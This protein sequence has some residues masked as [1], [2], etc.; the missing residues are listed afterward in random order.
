MKHFTVTLLFIS[1]F[2]VPASGQNFTQQTGDAKCTAKFAQALAIRGVHLGLSADELL[3]M[4][5]DVVNKQVITQ[6][7]EAA[8]DYPYFGRAEIYLVP[9]G[10]ISREK[11]TGVQEI[12]LVLFDNRVVSFSVTYQGPPT[13]AHWDSANEFLTKLSETL[14]LPAAA[15]WVTTDYSG[16]LNCEGVQIMVSAGGSGSIYIS[17]KDWNRQLDERQKAYHNL[18]RRQFKP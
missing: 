12:S 13:G 18:K 2:A 6:K 15:H 11:L 3:A 16:N 7:L 5:P 17:T 9:S 14:K 1:W 10:S 8:K 4:F